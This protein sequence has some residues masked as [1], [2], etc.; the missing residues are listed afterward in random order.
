MASLQSFQP[1]ADRFCSWL[2]RIEETADQLEKDSERIR[3]QYN[4]GQL[5]PEH[6][7]QPFKV[8]QNVTFIMIF[9]SHFEDVLSMLHSI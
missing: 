6:E 4:E 5:L 3:S 7:I 1:S 2:T 8:S 9:N